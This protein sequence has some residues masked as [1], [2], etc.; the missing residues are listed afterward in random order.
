[1][2]I[3]FY[4]WFTAES[5]GWRRFLADGFLG[6]LWWPLRLVS[7]ICVIAIGVVLADF[8]Q[9]E[10]GLSRWIGVPL[11]VSFML[12]L[13]WVLTLGRLL[14]FFPFPPCR[15]GQCR[16]IDAYTWVKGRIYGREKWNTYH[17]WC[18][19][20]DEYIREGRRLSYVLPDGTQ[21]PY[22][23]L[24][25][26]RKWKTKEARQASDGDDNSTLRE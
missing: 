11:S 6:I 4:K 23:I 18:R 13:T 12:L 15:Q 21:K 7:S 14:F 8:F 20:G 19:C 24:D 5:W 3:S 17:Y 2:K 25:G 16:T 1:M 9:R 10:I 22:L 26:F